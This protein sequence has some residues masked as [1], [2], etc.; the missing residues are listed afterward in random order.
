MN[1][2]EPGSQ[3]GM[4]SPRSSENDRP[5][6]RCPLQ[7]HPQRCRQDSCSICSMQLHV[8]SARYP[9]SCHPTLD[10]SASWGALHVS[11]FSRWPPSL[12]V[13]TDG[14]HCCGSGSATPRG[15]RASILSAVPCGHS[16]CFPSH[17]LCAGL[18]A[19]ALEGERVGHDGT[20]VGVAGPFGR[21]MALERYWSAPRANGSRA[22]PGTTPHVLVTEEPG[23]SLRGG[24]QRAPPQADRGAARKQ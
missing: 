9:A 19:V 12:R 8:R 22:R 7:R 1:L 24:V 4:N 14:T 10:P 16:S 15:G 13:A 5:R 18:D 20:C 6:S 11:A 21:L 2:S 23:S 17:F 3:S